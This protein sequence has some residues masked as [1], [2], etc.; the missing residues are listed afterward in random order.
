MP[1]K[2]EVRL[3][4]IAAKL[5]ISTVT[6]SKALSNKDGVGDDLRKEIKQ[7]A[8][9][10]GYR[11]KKTAAAQNE[12]ST[13]NIGIIIPARFFSP[14]Y[15]FY[16]H[17]FNQLSKTLLEKDYYSIMELVSD[18]D[19][20]EQKLPRVISDEKVDG[21]IFLGQMNAQFIANVNKHFQKFLLLDFYI[22]NTD[23]DCVINDDFYN[24]Y[25]M[26]SYVI[27][28]GHRDIRFV[29]NFNATT[30]ISDRFMGF[31]KAMYE[32]GFESCISQILPDRD[33]NGMQTTIP[34]PS[35]DKMPTAF[36]CNSDLTAVN[37]I[38]QLEQKG[39]KIPQDISVTGYDNFV[40]EN[41]KT[42]PLTTVYINPENTAETVAD[43]LIK[44]ISGEKYVPGR[45]L[46]S[47]C[48]I[49][50]DSVKT[51]KD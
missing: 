1:Q 38:H 7:I 51:L 3:S 23:Y 50:R 37:L 49:K 34:L 36:I 31:Q 30:S 19:E 12:N 5:N 33:E 6:V 27:N 40:S 26:T 10:M 48:I 2:K 46:V 4:D 25:Q 14:N 20:A 45:H 39:Y 47:G 44:K 28:C 13:G 41:E 42:V 32:H 15:S 21:V 24:S 11:Q 16:W 43:L 18:Q 35:K 17:I 9:E 8:Q 29:G 22:N